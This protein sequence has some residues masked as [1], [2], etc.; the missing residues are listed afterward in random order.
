M[1][2]LITAFGIDVKLIII[3]ILNFGILLGLLGYFLYKPILA[4]LATREEKIAQ[5]MKDAEDAA[6]AKASAD[7]EKKG[8]LSSAHKDAEEV[9]AKAKTYAEEK[10]V[11][12]AAEAQTKAES[13]IKNAE[14]K[15]E[16]L[17]E[18]AR[19][20]SEAEIAKLAILAAGKILQ[21][22]KST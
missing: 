8:I 10:A 16:E 13:I 1:E 11:V 7:E 17:K 3:Q 15:S 5:G 4:M 14:A 22:K 18:Q 20:D 9:G 6:K 2:Q 12:I 19:K 21:E